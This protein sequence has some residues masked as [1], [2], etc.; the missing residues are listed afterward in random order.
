MK[1]GDNTIVALQTPEERKIEEDESRQAQ[2]FA[3]KR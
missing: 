3:K 1:E 2:A